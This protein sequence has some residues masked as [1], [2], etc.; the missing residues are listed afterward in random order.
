MNGNEVADGVGA[1]SVCAVPAGTDGDD[2]DE[3]MVNG[4]EVNVVLPGVD[5]PNKKAA[6]TGAGKGAADK[7]AV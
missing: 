4:G 1:G 6:G 2:F 3:A 7:G 5:V